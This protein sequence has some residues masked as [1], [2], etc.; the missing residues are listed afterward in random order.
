M[1]RIFDHLVKACLAWRY[2]RSK[3]RRPPLAVHLRRVLRGMWRCSDHYPAVWT[4]SPTNLI[5]AEML[6]CDRIVFRILQG[7]GAAGTILQIQF[8]TYEIIPKTQLPLQVAQAAVSISL[9]SLCGPLIGG[10]VSE[11]TSWRWIFLI[12]VPAGFAA[13]IPLFL[14]IPENFP[15]QGDPSYT[16]PS[17]R[18]R[19]SPPSIK[20]LDGTG[21]FLLLGTSTIFVT[22]LLEAGTEFA[23]N[24]GTSIA[25][26]I[27]SGVLLTV[28]VIHEKG[29]T[30][31]TRPQEPMFLWRFVYNREWMG[32]L[33][34]S[35]L[36]AVPYNIVSIDLPE[37]FQTIDGFSPLQ[38]GIRLLPFNAVTAFGGILVNVIAGK[39][40]ILP[41]YL[42][43]VGAIMEL[44]GLA[45]LTTLPQ[46]GTFSHNIYGYQALTGLGICVVLGIAPVLPP[47]LVEARDLAVASGAFQQCRILGGVI[48][49]S[50]GTSV[51]NNHVS[52]QLVGVLGPTDLAMLQGSTSVIRNFP[53]SV[54]AK[55]ID[56]F[57]QGYNLQ[58]KV[59]TAFGAAHILAVGMLWR[60]KQISVVEGKKDPIVEERPIPLIEEQEC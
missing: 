9:G 11:R 42:I 10:A 17:W 3:T 57:A 22:V 26:F 34:I 40:R 39:T 24:S 36:S 2:L 51:L 48:G 31:E 44:V 46:N 52:S 47:H 1:G 21:V 14:R 20:R 29:L 33:L 50:I 18:E 58:F 60:K 38:A 6:M 28:L 25:L 12:D 7:I 27:V 45:L 32:T 16:S 43:L 56:A 4:T 55:I 15:Y 53:P 30:S 54:Q 13:M 37:R 8:I 19:F 49:L 23:W 41:I 5:P 59:M 35:L